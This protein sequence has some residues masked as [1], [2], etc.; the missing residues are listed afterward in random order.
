[1]TNSDSIATRHGCDWSRSAWASPGCAIDWRVFPRVPSYP[2]RIAYKLGRP[3]S[4]SSAT[5]HQA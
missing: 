2:R 5:H 1:M 4:T 3:V